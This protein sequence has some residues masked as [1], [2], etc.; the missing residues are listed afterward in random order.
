MQ[1]SIGTLGTGCGKRKPAPSLGVGRVE[2]RCLV[3]RDEG[4]GI[5][6]LVDQILSVGDQQLRVLGIGR[7][8]RGIELVGAGVVSDSLQ[9]VSLCQQKLLR[10]GI[11]RDGSL[12][13]L[14]GPGGQ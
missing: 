12:E 2:L 9:G 11:E 6:E 1:G 4:F 13:V 7:E 10:P 5:E 3:E 14:T 8:Q